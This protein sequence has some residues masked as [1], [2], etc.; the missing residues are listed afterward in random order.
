V[1]HL[2]ETIP[3]MW[4][5]DNAS[6]EQ[7]LTLELEFGLGLAVQAMVISDV[8]GTSGVQTQA[9]STSVLQTL[10]KTLTR[11]ETQGYAPQSIW[12]NPNDFEA[13]ELALSTVNAVEHVGLPYDAAARR[14]WG[15]P[16]VVSTAVTAG[17]SYSVAAG[18]VGLN[19]DTR[20]VE[21]TWSEASNADDWSRNLSRARTE[22]RFCTSVFAPLGICIGDLTP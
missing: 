19:S 5:G 3:R 6:L 17:V 1:A 22:G 7:F 14:L 9:Y 20:G 4:L 2:S 13:V 10:R 15:V 12:V 21:T 8:A 11:L 16:L 18:A